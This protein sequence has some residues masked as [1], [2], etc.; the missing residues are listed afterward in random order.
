MKTAIENKFEEISICAHCG[1]PTNEVTYSCGNGWDGN[2]ICNGCG[3]IE[4]DTVTKFFCKDCEEICDEET[5]N[6]K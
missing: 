5:C 1:E 4:P 6:C 2:T 3:M